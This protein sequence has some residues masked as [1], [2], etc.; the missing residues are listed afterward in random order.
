M[1]VTVTVMPCDNFS[2][3]IISQTKCD[4]VQEKQHKGNN[5]FMLYY[6]FFF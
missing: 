4:K 3:G 2:Q 6:K 5:R 1:D